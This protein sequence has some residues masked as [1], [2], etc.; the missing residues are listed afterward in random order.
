MERFNWISIDD[1]YKWKKS[2]GSYFSNAHMINHP[3]IFVSHHHHHHHTCSNLQCCIFSIR[4]SPVFM[5]LSLS[6]L[7]LL[8]SSHSHYPSSSPSPRISTFFQFLFHSLALS[9]SFFSSSSPCS[10][11]FSPLVLSFPPLVVVVV[12][13]SD[14]KLIL[15]SI[16]LQCV[17]TFFSFSY[18]RLLFSTYGFYFVSS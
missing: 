1:E 11:V 12:A 8:T 6:F 14:S 13:D 4:C 5:S 2:C 16:F 18:S 7:P 15:L 3:S 17:Q 10:L 9:L